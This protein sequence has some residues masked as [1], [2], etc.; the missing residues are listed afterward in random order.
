MLKVV[1][2][3]ID[4]PKSDQFIIKKD[5]NEF[6]YAYENRTIKI[7]SALT[8]KSGKLVPYSVYNLK[9]LKNFSTGFCCRRN[10][11]LNYLSKYSFENLETIN[12]ILFIVSKQRK[13]HQF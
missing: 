1:D 5:D 8:S 9:N 4:M 6:K 7:E 13:E 11:D 2:S 12:I 3:I 10:F